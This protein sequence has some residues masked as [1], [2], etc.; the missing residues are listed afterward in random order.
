M[1]GRGAA[2]MKPLILCSLT[3][4]AACHP[5]AERAQDASA[6]ERA[7]H[8][9][10]MR[11]LELERQRDSE[12]SR[13]ELR[14]VEAKLDALNQ[15]LDALIA[16]GGAA[17]PRP[18]RVEPDRAKVYAVPP[19]GRARGSRWIGCSGRRASRTASSITQLI[20]EELKK[21]SERIAAG[22]PAAAY[23]QKWVLDQGLRSVTP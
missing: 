5:G 12:R 23:Y 7:R 3:L 19:P 2:G 20:D 13:E 22:T 18:Q 6:V 15:K 9:E 8:A 4:A 14:R 16:R 17:R 11:S 1:I 10:E 21:A